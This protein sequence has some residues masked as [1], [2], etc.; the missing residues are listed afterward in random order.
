MGKCT[1]AV[2]LLAL[3]LA[4]V[5]P[6]GSVAAANAVEDATEAYWAPAWLKSHVNISLAIRCE[7]IDAALLR[8]SIPLVLA[9]L[10]WSFVV[11]A[12]IKRN[13]RLGEIVVPLIVQLPSGTQHIL[14]MNETAN[15]PIVP[16]SGRRLGE[17]LSSSSNDTGIL[18]QVSVIDPAFSTQMIRDLPQP[19]SNADLQ[20]FLSDIVHGQSNT[21]QMLQT[22]LSI[23]GSFLHVSADQVV[24][25]SIVFYADASAN[26][27]GVVMPGDVDEPSLRN[28]GATDHISAKLTQSGVIGLALGFVAVG[29][30]AATVI[31]SSVMAARAAQGADGSG[32]QDAHAL[33]RIKRTKGKAKRRRSSGSNGSAGGRP[34]AP[35]PTIME[36]GEAEPSEASEESGSEHAATSAPVH[37]VVIDESATD[38][39]AASVA[40]LAAS[41]TENDAA[42]EDEG[43]AAK[44]AA[45]VGL[46]PQSKRCGSSKRHRIRLTAEK[47]MQAGEP[48]SPCYSPGF[49]PGQ[50]EH[51][52]ASPQRCGGAL[53]VG[54]FVDVEPADVPENAE[55]PAGA[56]ARAHVRGATFPLLALPPYSPTEAMHGAGAYGAA[57]PR[58]MSLRPQPVPGSHLRRGRAASF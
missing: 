42:A 32:A 33:A 38:G 20:G 44:V 18:V 45:G 30:V 6:W 2:T 41:D 24:V 11:F 50:P 39:T 49:K 25:S 43:A 5:W 51:S 8:N 9:D 35:L 22:F 4:A 19:R 53:P 21:P 14:R 15:T 55:P 13:V 17:A 54:P 48:Q 23:W 3:L 31:R 47:A 10:R 46:H 7:G 12:G 56:G 29:T 57:Y 40:S 52:E 27:S 58:T 34:L 1:S 28:L 26:S 16:N 37:V 36:E